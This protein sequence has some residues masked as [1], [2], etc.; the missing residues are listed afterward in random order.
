MFRH[1]FSLFLCLPV[2]LRLPFSVGL[3]LFVLLSACLS[4]FKMDLPIV[5]SL[6]IDIDAVGSVCH[7]YSFFY[8]FLFVCSLFRVWRILRFTS[9]RVQGHPRSVAKTNYCWPIIW[10]SCHHFWEIS[11][12]CSFKCLCLFTDWDRTQSWRSSCWSKWIV[13]TKS[14]F[15]DRRTPREEDSNFSHF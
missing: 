7:E 6:S 10:R 15:L 3:F 5:S 14:T 8:V 4:I 12:I 9:K 1:V 11:Y 13:S 2:Y